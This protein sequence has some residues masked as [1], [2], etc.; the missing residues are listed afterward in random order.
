MAITFVDSAVGHS[1]AQGV[2][3]RYAW[4]VFGLTFGLLLSD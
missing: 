2:S 3:R 4:T 1:A